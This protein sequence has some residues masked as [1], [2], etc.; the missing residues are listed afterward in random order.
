MTARWGPANTT[1]TRD[2]MKE[3][4]AWGRGGRGLRGGGGDTEDRMTA[5]W[6]PTKA[7]LE[8]RRESPV[9]GGGGRGLRG[10]GGEGGEEGDII[11]WEM[12]CN[13][14]HAMLVEKENCMFICLRDCEKKNEFHLYFDHP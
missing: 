11:Y 2:D 14:K 5:I 6:G 13:H 12:A 8:D 4:S 3:S 9:W 10:G 1:D 7:T